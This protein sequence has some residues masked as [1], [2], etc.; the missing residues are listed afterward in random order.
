MEF[1]Y[2]NFPEQIYTCE[3]FTACNVCDLRMIFSVPSPC[4]N[5]LVPI[6]SKA[7]FNAY[8]D[9]DWPTNKGL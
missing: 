1:V 9:I 7:D 3:Y 4:F 8:N 6:G 2:V 5:A